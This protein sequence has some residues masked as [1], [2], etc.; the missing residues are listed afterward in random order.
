MQ[1]P[2]LEAPLSWKIPL[3]LKSVT[4]EFSVSDLCRS[5]TNIS[6]LYFLYHKKRYN[7]SRVKMAAGE[8]SHKFSLEEWITVIVACLEMDCMTSFCCYYSIHQIPTEEV[9]ELAWCILT[10]INGGPV[11]HM[12]LNATAALPIN[13]T[14]QPEP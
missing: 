13:A 6:I 9:R 12:L 7:I 8:G 14:L 1:S 4:V 11:G 10:V 2:M 3:G 5:V